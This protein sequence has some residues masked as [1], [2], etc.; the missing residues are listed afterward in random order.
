M[1][2]AVCFDLWETLVA[3]PPG[4]GEDRA[5]DRAR[6]VERALEAAG[7]PAPPEAIAGA[8][9]N[10]IDA[11]VAV[12]QRNDDLG[13]DERLALF[14][15]HLDPSLR[16]KRDLE[17]PARAAIAEA[18]LGGTER[19]PPELLPGAD[20][21]LHALR[22]RGVAL[23]LVSNTGLSPGPVLVRTLERLGITGYFDAL[24]FSDE[25]RAWKPDARMF[26]AAVAALGVPPELTAFVGDTPETDIVGAQAFGLGL[27]ALVGPA[28]IDG[29]QP[30]LRL[31]G[32]DALIPALDARGLLNP[33]A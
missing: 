19:V 5:G 14:Y 33:E 4:R 18:I 32:V 11:L 8:I 23:A 28:A 22:R 21:T 13:A 16:P 3:D 30:D 7:R 24:I 12:H 2:R 6:A 29:V 17:P 31:G 26:A 20:E 27:T 25:V 15:E 1:L 9:Q 10:T